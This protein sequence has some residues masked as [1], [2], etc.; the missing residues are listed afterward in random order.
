MDENADTR[1]EAVRRL[2]DTIAREGYR[3]DADAVAAAILRRLLESRT[4]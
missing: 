3:V 4:L 2:R 1:E